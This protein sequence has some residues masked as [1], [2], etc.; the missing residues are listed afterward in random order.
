MDDLLHLNQMQSFHLH[1][2]K[3][4]DYY[5]W[6]LINIINTRYRST[7]S[8]VIPTTVFALSEYTES[9]TIKVPSDLLNARP[10]FAPNEPLSLNCIS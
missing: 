7:V 8:L 5:S 4:L 2:H 6:I 3:L 10:E 1:P 9:P